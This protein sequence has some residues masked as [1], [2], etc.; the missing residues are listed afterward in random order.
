MARL[1]RPAIP[2]EVKVR[3]L[4]RQLGE[5]FPDAVVAEHRRGL[6][7]FA[8]ALQGRLADLL[9][10]SP[11]DLRLDHDPAL[12]LRDRTGEGRKTVYRPDANDPDFLA[13][14]P[15]GT[16]FA[17]S[18]D[19]KTRIRGDN[20]QFS[21]LT[22]IKRERRRQKRAAIEDSSCPVQRF[23][24]TKQKIRSGKTRWPKRPL[25]PRKKP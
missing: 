23:L 9:Q 25:N 11:S 14:R 8:A 17:G 12:A 1:F 6:G 7:S 20:G 24:K 13:Y 5:M 18:H 15:H 3:V 10:C 16:E 4:L 21:D 22:L 19:V 2:I